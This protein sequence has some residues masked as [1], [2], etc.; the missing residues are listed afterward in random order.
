MN[1]FKR[2]LELDFLRFI[3]AVLVVFYH[4]CFRGA[5]ADDMSLISFE[6]VSQIA[7]Y[8]YLGVELFFMISGF[9]ILYSAQNSSALNFTISR[10][11]RLYPTFWACV[12][13]TSLSSLLI[14]GERY[15][16]TITQVLTNLTMIPSIFN[17]SYVDG[18]YWTLLVE[19][20]FYFLI[21]CLLLLKSSHKLT[22][23]LF[24]WL[25]VS[26]IH[27]V[28]PLP[29]VIEFFL[30][31]EE[32]SLFIAG[33]AFYLASKKGFNAIIVSLLSASMIISIIHA[34]NNVERLEQYYNT[35]FSTVLVCSFIIAQ[36]LMFTLLILGKLQFLSI[37]SFYRLGAL[38][39]PL[40]LLHQNF[41]FMLF[42]LAADDLPN[43]AVFLMTTAIVG[44][45]CLL[46]DKYIERKLSPLFRK[47]LHNLAEKFYRSR[48]KHPNA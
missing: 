19:I 9:V 42:N 22:Y 8:G 38:T 16:V 28:D 10:A 24:I 36:H 6:K 44:S 13:I 15:Q 18:V 27:I 29:N 45:I 46:I 31:P 33:A 7:K 11:A 35:H 17:V 32:A 23:F 47:S 4:Y 20:K 3:A 5:A 41:G 25:T 26:I 37:K 34:T 2:Y 21:F 43:W 1:D 39:Y 40:Y 14:G 12:L 48:S 30:I